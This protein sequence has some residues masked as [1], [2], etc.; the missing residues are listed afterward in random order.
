MLKPAVKKSFLLFLSGFVWVLVGIMLNTFAY[1]WMSSFIGSYHFLYVL[2]GLLIGLIIH[3]FGF[4]RIVDKNLGRIILLPSTPCVFSFMSWKSYIIVA[5]MI[6]LGAI[7]RHSSI[8]KQFLS[9]IY[10]AIGSALI[11]SSLRYF[12][13]LFFRP[14]NE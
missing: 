9:I 4:L 7:L 14:N 5:V 8:P 6:S 1:F 10:I 11:L 13:I 2:V 3:H 12:R